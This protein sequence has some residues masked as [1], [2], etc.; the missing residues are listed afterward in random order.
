MIV[1]NTPQKGCFK[2]GGMLLILERLND[3]G[4]NS[5]SKWKT[6]LLLI[7]LGILSLLSILCVCS[8]MLEWT[9][10]TKIL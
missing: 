7:T 1:D 3:G 4:S 5:N 10:F 9:V 6:C 2:A 8:F